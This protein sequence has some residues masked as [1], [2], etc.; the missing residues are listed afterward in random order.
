MKIQHAILIASAALAVMTVSCAKSRKAGGMMDDPQTHTLQGMKY[1]DKQDYVHARDEFKLAISLEEGKKYCP[2]WAGLAMT[3]AAEGKI[4]DAEDNADKAEGYCTAKEYQGHMAEAIV[5]EFK[6]KG[7][8]DNAEWWKDAQKQYKK[9]L[10]I[11]P[12]SGELHFRAGHMYKIAYEFRLAEDAFRKNLELKNG[13]EE[14]SNKEWAVVQ[15]IVRAEPGTR[16]GKRIALVEKISRADISA[17]FMSELDL[18]KI[19]DKSKA[20][21]YE[22]SFTAP[23]DP[24]QFN[25][26]STVK[27]AAI[28]DCDSH[29]A[30]NF[31]NDVQKYRIRG[32]EPNADHKFYPDSLITRGEYAIFIE[33]ILMAITGDRTLATKHIGNNESRFPDVNPSSPYYNAIC[34]AV[35][36]NIMAGD[37]TGE[38]RA[39]DPVSGPDALLIIRAIKD[40]RR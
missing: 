35:D 13:Y 12:T 40:L 20:K 15:K 26:D 34:N 5:I 30:R 14:E 2:A 7:D 9:A 38:F 33:D 23:A 27:K 25:A 24:R 21:N 22:T 8:K 3:D 36:K 11:A 1:W 10:E 17:L 29:W 32:L 28:L 4:K 39:Q 37:L 18:D 31:I 6:Y 16:V 19:L